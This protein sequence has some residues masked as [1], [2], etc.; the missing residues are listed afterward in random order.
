MYF[1]LLRCTLSTFDK[2]PNEPAQ[3][4]DSKARKKPSPSIIPNIVNN[5]FFK[6]SSYV[7][8]TYHVIKDQ[9][10]LILIIQ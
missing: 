2:V 5:N 9:S 10:K 8:K 6:L 4:A 1:T 7:Y 3:N